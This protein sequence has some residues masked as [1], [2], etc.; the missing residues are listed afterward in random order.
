LAGWLK[1][2][3]G[4]LSAGRS[5]VFLL[6]LAFA[7]AFIAS[8]AGTGVWLTAVLMAM[9]T[10]VLAHALILTPL[11]RDY[12]THLS[13]RTQGATSNTVDALTRVPN[14]RG[15]T[16][17]LLEAM[18]YANRY[19]HPLSVAL[20]DLDMLAN[21]NRGMG[22]RA[23]DKALQAVASVFT[24][25]VRMP[26]HAGRYGDEEFLVILPNT[27]LKNA[28]TIAERIRDGVESAECSF[29]G[30]KIPVTVSI[31]ASQFH[32]GE[33]LERFL[34]RV[35]KALAA[36]KASGRN[37]VVAERRASAKGS[38]RAAAERRVSVSR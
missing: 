1:D 30:K 15:I 22:R 13:A 17:S 38:N 7:G 12:E 5:F 37:R 19:N 9:L 24:D 32:K 25:T 14:R 23:G 4:G 26:D 31:G 21:I 3:E 18:S 33:D 11:A 36:A 29:N 28:T 27:T 16:A 2:A 6:L 34:A 8:A 10:A 20:V 35:D